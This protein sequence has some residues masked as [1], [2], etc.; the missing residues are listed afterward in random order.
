MSIDGEVSS[1]PI[2]WFRASF[3]RA[4]QSEPFDACR[5]A[6]ATSD[7][8]GMPAVRF[9][10]VREVDDRGFAFFTNLTS[11]KAE[12][13][14]ARPVA[15]L[16]FHW[17]TIGEQVRVEGAI[18]P[19]SSQESDAYFA[20]RPRA[21]QIA[22][23]A[24]EQSASIENRAALDARYRE[25]ELRFSD[26]ERVP[27]PEHWGGLRVVPARIEFWLSRDAR[28]HDR[29]SFMHDASGWSMVRLQP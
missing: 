23:W 13:L 3:A 12:H 18:E 15:A 4:Q 2:A 10:L 17:F 25:T 19:V 24:S 11:V 5:A 27:R 22:A 28:M 20:S 14:R 1:D 8:D 9:V 6:L 7:R 29:W 16:A 26:V 21:S